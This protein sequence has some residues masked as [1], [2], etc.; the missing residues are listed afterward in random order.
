LTLLGVEAAP[1][2]LLLLAPAAVAAA[3]AAGLPG[4]SLPKYR[5][6]MTACAPATTHDTPAGNSHSDCN[7]NRHVHISDPL[8]DSLQTH[9]HPQAL[10]FLASLLLLLFMVH[11]R[12]MNTP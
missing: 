5:S 12:A 10:P 1:Q 8:H 6:V 9:N 11:A 2:L 3:A 7:F 4:I